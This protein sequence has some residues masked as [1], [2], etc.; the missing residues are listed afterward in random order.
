MAEQTTAPVANQGGGSG[1]T[2]AII[3]VVLLLLCCCCATLLGGFFFL[4]IGSGVTAITGVA[5]NT[6]CESSGKTLSSIYENQ[7]TAGFRARVSE[8]E[9]N[10]TMNNLQSVCKD[11]KNLDSLSALTKGLNINYSN[12]NGKENLN[13]SGNLGGKKVDLKMVTE[14]GELKIDDLNVK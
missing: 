5:S 14:D 12:D 4:T 9:F 11:L 1:K 2:I 7:T 3:V 10:A 13:F 8:T 6:V